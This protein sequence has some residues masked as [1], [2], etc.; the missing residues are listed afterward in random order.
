[1]RV[2]NGTI[3]YHNHIA[4]TEDMSPASAHSPRAWLVASLQD[5][6]PFPRNG[7]TSEARRSDKD[8]HTKQFRYSAESLKNCAASAQASS[9]RVIRILDR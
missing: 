4:E 7:G 3:L 2:G 5:I 6:P 9:S 8:F 1:M